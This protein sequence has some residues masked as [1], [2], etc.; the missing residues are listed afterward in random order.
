MWV[1][2]AAVYDLVVK[3]DRQQGSYSSDLGIHA[4]RWAWILVYLVGS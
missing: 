1:S 3:A 4:A 2:P